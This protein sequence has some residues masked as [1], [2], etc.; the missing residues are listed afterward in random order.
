MGLAN[1]LGAINSAIHLAD[2]IG[3]S[4]RVIWLPSSALGAKYMDL[5]NISEHFS[6]IDL[7]PSV[8]TIDK[9][10][11]AVLGLRTDREIYRWIRNRKYD[12]VLEDHDE[13]CD[14]R[15]PDFDFESS[16][17]FIKGKKILISTC[18]PF[19]RSSGSGFFSPSPTSTVLNEI[20]K[21]KSDWPKIMVGVHIRRTDH[22][23]AIKHAPLFKFFE[24]IDARLEEEPG[25]RFFLATDCANVQD[26]IINKYR[27]KF[28]FREKVFGRSSVQAM[29]DALI[30]LHLLSHCSEI[31][32]SPGSTFSSV[33]AELSRGPSIFVS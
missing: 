2:H 19:F 26:E 21:F 30:D 11:H 25:T 23:F 4:L 22:K 15:P 8:R 9:L 29:R 32:K 6:L 14:I 28:F 33:A 27:G 18:F 7:D 1:R 24:A 17:Q 31:L 13:P 3:S 16:S 10:H 5:F 20:N 12:S